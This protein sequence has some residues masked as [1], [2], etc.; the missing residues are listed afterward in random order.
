MR[1]SLQFTA[2]DNINKGAPWRDAWLGTNGKELEGMDYRI[3]MVHFIVI[4]AF[5]G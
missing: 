3:L 4:Y 5:D 1:P 2:K